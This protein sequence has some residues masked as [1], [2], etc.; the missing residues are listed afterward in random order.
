M[1][2]FVLYSRQNVDEIV[3]GFVVF[4]FLDNFRAFCYVFG[5]AR[6]KQHP[7]LDAADESVPSRCTE[8]IDVHTSATA[9]R[10]DE[11]PSIRRSPSLAYES[12]SKSVIAE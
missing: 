1:C 8:W 4:A 11:K 12:V 2:V 10:S 6:G 7:A 3:G 5:R 9:F